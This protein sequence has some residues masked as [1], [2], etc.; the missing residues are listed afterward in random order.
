V[1][2]ATVRALSRSY[3][4]GEV[5]LEQDQTKSSASNPVLRK[6]EGRDVW[7]LTAYG[8][9]GLILFGVLAYF[10]SQYVAN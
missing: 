9:S 10:F 4:L 8:L 6:K 5:V 1:S 3:T 2:R 7:V